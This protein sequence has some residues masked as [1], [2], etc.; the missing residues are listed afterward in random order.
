MDSILNQDIKYLQGVGPRRKD[1]LHK[2][3]GIVSYGDLIEHYPYKYVDRSKIYRIDE[4]TS[5]MP[6]V[7]VK[8]H[9]LSFEQTTSGYRKTIVTA[10]FSDG[11]AVCDLVW[12]NGAK[13]VR[14]NYNCHKEYIVFGKPT[15]F[16][17]RI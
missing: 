7:Q 16:N 2:E 14:A 6:F 13:M 4:L 11:T 15:V 3:L 9:I 8:G 17:H 12:F 10:H 1:I 5:D